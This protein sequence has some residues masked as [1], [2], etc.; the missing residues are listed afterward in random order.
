MSDTFRQPDD[1]SDFSQCVYGVHIHGTLPVGFQPYLSSAVQERIDSAPELKVTYRPIRAIPAG[2][3][4]W[5][6]EHK[7]SLGTSRF[8]L[9]KRP[10]GLVLDVRCLGQGRF[11]ITPT[12]IGIE[13]ISGGTGPAHY[14]FSHALPL[15]LEW[16]GIPVLHASA[17]ALGDRAVAFIGQSGTGKSTL[18][19]SLVRL[20][21]SFVADDGLALSEDRQ[22][23][24]RCRCG[25]PL[26]RLWPSALEG[27]LET[28]AAEL[29]RVHPGLEKR[30]LPLPQ[31]RSMK[32]EPCL[33][34]VYI[35][36]RQK[37]ASGGV[38]MAACPASESLA[39]LV[40]HSLAGAPAAALG[41]QAT[42][43]EQ[44]SRVV[45]TTRVKYLS[46]PSGAEQS[47]AV[48]QAIVEDLN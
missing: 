26:I 11:R 35:L 29:A 27:Y 4:L 44:L 10:D 23:R 17:A 6:G 46:Y 8:V 32:A 21:W 33:S 1:L 38:V 5:V 42:R 28:S 13:W 19:A 47:R 40:E 34:A 43:L 48:L 30:I 25:P 14:F 18:C 22:R 12:E 15:W 9:G 39:R 36:E 7:S 45:S 3:E 37:E 20:G 16:R 31:K 41:L 2:D 24:W